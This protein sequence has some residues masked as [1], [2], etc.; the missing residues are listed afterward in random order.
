MVQIYKAIKN[1]E[2]MMQI[3]FLR[4]AD[5]KLIKETHSLLEKAEMKLEEQA[6]QYCHW[7]QQD[8]QDCETWMTS[9]GDQLFNVINGTPKEN[10]MIFCP[11]CGKN[12][13]EHD[14][15]EQFA[16]EEEEC[17]DSWINDDI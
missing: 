12:I 2:K 10:D 16:N 9:C 7:Y 4:V 5:V 1:L 17:D 11:Y 15:N 14:Y 6:E 3:P 8:F 13:V